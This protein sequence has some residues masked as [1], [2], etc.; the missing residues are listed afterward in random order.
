MV[1]WTTRSGALDSGDTARTMSQENVQIV[2]AAFEAVNRGDMDGAWV[3]AAPDFQLDL[4]RALGPYRGVYGLSD[5]R[6]VADEFWGT[7]E[8][9]RFEV[10]EFLDAGNHVVTPFTNLIKGREAIEVQTRGAWAWTIVDGAV[11]RLC[12]YQERVEA[13]EAVGLSE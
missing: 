5:V 7:W 12:L 13:L 4:S 3:R 9:S 11:T 1:S 8:S 6:R 10:D 2:R